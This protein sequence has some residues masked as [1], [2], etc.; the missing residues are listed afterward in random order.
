MNILI[1]IDDKII[2]MVKEMLFSIRHY[3][4]R[5]NLY[6]IYNN[7]KIENIDDLNRFMNSND[8][9]ELKLIKYNCDSFRF[10]NYV[11]HITETAYYRLF[12]CYY[13]KDNIDRILYLDYDIFCSGS[14]LELYNTNFENKTIVGIEDF[15]LSNEKPNYINSGVLLIDVKKYKNKYTE[16]DIYK[17]ILE[18]YD[19]LKYGDQDVINELFYEDIKL[20]DATYNFQTNAIEHTFDYPII[21]HYANEYKP[22]NDNYPYPEK[23]IPYYKNLCLMGMKEKAIQLSKKHFENQFYNWFNPSKYSE[24]PTIDIIIPSWNAI[25][26]IEKTLDS[27]VNQKLENLFITV[28]LVDDCSEEDYSKIVNKYNNKLNLVYVKTDIN[29]GVAGARQKGID[30][31]DGDYFTIIDS[32][33]KY[34]S[35]YSILSMCYAAI[36]SNADVVRSIFLEDFNPDYGN[37][38]L[39]RNNNIACHGKLYKRSFINK[40]KIRFLNLRGNEDTAYNYL[41]EACG[42]KYFDL[43]IITYLYCY[44]PNSFTKQ[45]SYHDK[46]LITFTQAY[47]WAT[48]EIIKR[49]DY[50]INIPEKIATIIGNIYLRIFDAYHHETQEIM[51]ENTA[52]IYFLYRKFTSEKLS[53]II[54]KLFEIDDINKFYYFLF[55]VQDKMR[56]LDEYKNLSE[57]EK[58]EFGDLFTD[59]KNNQIEIINSNLEKR[60]NCIIGEDSIINY[61]VLFNLYNS[62]IIG[63]NVKI[64]INLTV[65]GHSKIRIGDNTIIGNNV[66]INT[67][68]HPISPKLRNMKYSGSVN[69]GKN[70]YIGNNV[71]ISEGVSIG[72]N[73]YIEDGSVIFDSIMPNSVASGNPCRVNREIYDLDDNYYNEDIKVN[74]DII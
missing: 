44:N 24:L 14:L 7:L 39:H 60:T 40:N 55:V 64:G 53:K 4:D 30:V 68:K 41:I 74:V 10:P 52:K 31:G 27:I 8:I 3:N 54:N 1:S 42:A 56:D 63:N 59:N 46:D 18:N 26:T 2:D 9:G 43:N 72:E 67:D 29:S 6:V 73:S 65:V 5:I 51:F 47:I 21:V 15:Y 36:D 17:Y 19:R 57:E 28:Y 32:D 48:Q 12:A 66:T 50:I 71:I 38:R 33:D 37:Y 58:I 34:I 45:D 20:I 70:V 49:R 25:S 69:I 62:F 11:K 35:N 23:A 16:D 13:L 22:W 61:P